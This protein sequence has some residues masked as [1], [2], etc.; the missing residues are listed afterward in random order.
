MATS[1]E[2][3]RSRLNKPNCAVRQAVERQRPYPYFAVPRRNYL[4]VYSAQQ[5]GR[6][7]PAAAAASRTVTLVDDLPQYFCEVQQ[8][9]QAPAPMQITSLPGSTWFANI[10]AK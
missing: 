9:S 1:L 2:R 5:L 8:G 4:P 7:I 10:K 3:T 6:P